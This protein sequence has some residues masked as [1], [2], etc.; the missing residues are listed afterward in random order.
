MA[1]SQPNPAQQEPQD[2]GHVPITEEFD[3]PKHTMPD[4][5][6]VIIALAIVAIAV[7]VIA[8]VFRATPVATGTIA[9]GRMCSARFRTRPTSCSSIAPTHALPSPREC[10]TSIRFSILA[11]TS[12]RQ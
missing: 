4:A 11:A 7:A 6:P 12:W 3:S 1:S 8:Y 5:A 10:A 2:A 9:S